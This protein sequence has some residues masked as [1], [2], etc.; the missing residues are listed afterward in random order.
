M[1]MIEGILDPQSPDIQ[2]SVHA[3]ICGSYRSEWILNIL[4]IQKMIS[5]QLS[6]SSFQRVSV[7]IFAIA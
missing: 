7:M 4:E 1:G 5:N 6:L 2:F 3:T